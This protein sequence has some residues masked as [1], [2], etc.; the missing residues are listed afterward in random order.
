M[1]TRRAEVWEENE[2]NKAWFLPALCAREVI[3]GFKVKVQNI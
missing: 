3:Y 2:E 1:E